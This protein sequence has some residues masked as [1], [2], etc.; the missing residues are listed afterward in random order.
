MYNVVVKKVHVRYLISWWV[1]CT[2]RL[3]PTHEPY[4][5]LLPGRNPQGV[6]ALW[7][8]VI[9]PIH[10]CQ[11]HILMR[12]LLNAGLYDVVCRRGSL[13]MNVPRD[14]WRCWNSVRLNAWQ[15]STKH[16]RLPDS[17]RWSSCFAKDE[18]NV[19]YCIREV[20]G[21]SGDVTNSVYM[22]PGKIL[23]EWHEIVAYCCQLVFCSLDSVHTT[24]NRAAVVKT[25]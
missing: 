6:I 13:K 2:F 1:S 14:C 24:C 8:V 7:L 4:L 20:L 21:G 19:S 22:V 17:L 9:A 25:P 18:W 15:S 16:W 10:N 11:I 23:T 5:P 12:L 3:P